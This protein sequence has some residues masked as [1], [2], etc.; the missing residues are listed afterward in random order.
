M[1]QAPKTPWICR[2]K[3]LAILRSLS[4][5]EGEAVDWVANNAGLSST[6]LN[7]H[8][9]QLAKHGYAYRAHFNHT[10]VWL[11]PK[12]WETLKNHPEPAQ[13]PQPT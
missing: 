8:V 10:E 12:G 9:R 1:T 3:R 5:T 11:T 13:K 2:G 4:R 6:G 7:Y